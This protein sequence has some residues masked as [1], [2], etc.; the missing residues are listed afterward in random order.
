M[1]W[2]RLTA[3]HGDPGDPAEPIPDGSQTYDSAVHGFSWNGVSEHWVPE[4]D[5]TWEA[6][7]SCAYEFRLAAHARVINGYCWVYQD[8]WCS[9]YVTILVG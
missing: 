3:R 5:A 1:R 8:A 2:Y 6:R 7:E 9:K 4:G